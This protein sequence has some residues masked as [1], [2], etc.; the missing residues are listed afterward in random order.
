MAQTRRKSSAPQNL[1]PNLVAPHCNL[2]HW[3][4]SRRVVAVKYILGLI[5]TSLV[6]SKLTCIQISTM[7][8]SFTVPRQTT[9]GILPCAVGP[10]TG[11]PAA[12]TVAK[13]RISPATKRQ[14]SPFSRPP[15][16]GL[17][18]NNSSD[19][20]WLVFRFRSSRLLIRWHT[21]VLI[22]NLQQVFLKLHLF[23]RL[24]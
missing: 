16:I 12:L 14:L 23:H 17:A 20:P 2:T 19:C 22:K 11:H 7:T 6:P 1:P 24:I 8:N 13:T 10:P 3:P 9:I 21:T 5:G 18:G 15:A 4:G